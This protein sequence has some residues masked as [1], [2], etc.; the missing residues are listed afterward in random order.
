MNETLA[1]LQRQSLSLLITYDA[2]KTIH[3]ACGTIS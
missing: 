1:I 2:V 3:G